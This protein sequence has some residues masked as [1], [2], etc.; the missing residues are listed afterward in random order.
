[1]TAF[2]AS[3]AEDLPA[4]I[5]RALAARKSGHPAQ[6]LAI[7]QEAA[8]A[9][10]AH[11]GLRLE[12]AFDLRTLGRMAEAAALYRAVHDMHPAHPGALLGLGLCARDQGDAAAA[13]AWMRQARAADPTHLAAGLELAAELRRQGQA[14]PADAIY[15][16]VLDR[17]P[18][19]LAALL[20]RAL[21][22]RQHG[23]RASSRAWLERA[24]QADPTHP[25]ARL[26][27]AA[28]LRDLGEL[29]AARS[30]A[31][32]LLAHDPAQDRALLSL[33]LTE[34]AAG[35]L[36]AAL[37]VF[38]RAHEIRPDRADL[39]V[40][41][42]IEHRNL[43]DAAA[44]GRLLDQ[45][46]SLAP[47]DAAVLVQ[48]AEQAR[49]ANDVPH[50]HEIYARAAAR[51]PGVLALEL[52]LAESR[53]LL[54]QTF[55][56]LDQLARL[57]ASAAER[58]QVR[59]KRVSLL[60]RAGH[61][62]AALASAREATDLWP[63]NF[64][65][66]A[67]RILCESCAGDDATLAACFGAAPAQA[68]RDRARLERLRAVLHERA[69][70]R[71]AAMACLDRAEALEPGT[72]EGAF[73]TTR[74]ALGAL[75]LPRAK[76]ALDATMRATLA[77]T[78]LRGR[79]ENPS[80]THFGQLLDEFALDRPAI[81]AL[82]ATR[83]LPIPARTQAILR[84]VAA[85]PGS[86][87]AA[88]ELMAA[89]RASGGI[90]TPAPW[91]PSD[92][93]NAHI[94][95]VI[96]QFWDSA[97][98]P[99]DVDRIMRSWREANPDH[100]HRV[101]DADAAAAFITGVYG[102]PAGRAFARA[103]TGAQQADVFRLGY[104]AASGGIYADADDRAIAGLHAIIPPDA[105]LVLY[106]EDIG[107]IGNNVIAAAPG[108][109]VI[110]RAFHLALAAIARGDEDTV[111]LSTGPGLLTRALAETLA[112]GHKLDGITLLGHR[113]LFRA[114]AIHCTAAYKT[115]GAHWSNAG[116]M[117]K[118]SRRR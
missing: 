51:Q 78:R 90:G 42:A 94:P 6:S 109:A 15:A 31:E 116:E 27:L 53:A 117:R 88:L 89:L 40:Q 108:H 110:A 64:A 34:R 65:L 72:G 19:Q 30:H 13:L 100:T 118:N 76:A 91:L 4:Q 77:V 95:R 54:G 58:P 79:S 44:S 75:N 92:P 45:A 99:E 113:D 103:A 82:H 105:R 57:E 67:E 85:H 43:G 114:V 74:V 46:L 71:G 104:L 93:P 60:R 35:R 8:A 11:P 87:A 97:P 3:A 37:A 12:S 2:P 107:S 61:W 80:Q 21:C 115:T 16:E 70:E 7:F 59:L 41:M 22:A 73:L 84:Q 38:T 39:L 66:W 69:G 24:V 33:G 55:R 52:G 26:E 20:G 81:A 83:D 23:D 5:Q 63:G 14:D 48:C 106:Q 17:H 111:W 9:R 68:P 56:A 86:T 10:P 47:D 101:F 96:V 50:M 49:M 18:A 32:A 25:G 36:Q 98:P 29:D 1:M 112:R 28:E 102:A 62:P